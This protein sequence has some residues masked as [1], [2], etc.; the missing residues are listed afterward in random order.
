MHPLKRPPNVFA[1]CPRCIHR[2]ISTAATAASKRPKTPDYPKTTVGSV[3]A[4]AY[5]T[6]TKQKFKKRKKEEEAAGSKSLIY[7]GDRVSIVRGT[8]PENAMMGRIAEVVTLRSKEKEVL[9]ARCREVCL[10]FLL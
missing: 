9:L 10:L 4:R 5:A 2:P 1:R 3:Y 6:S 8:G 7:K